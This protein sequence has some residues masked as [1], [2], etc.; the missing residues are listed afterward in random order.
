MRAKTQQT[1]LDAEKFK[2]T[3]EPVP[4]MFD[5]NGVLDEQLN[6]SKVN[7]MNNGR[8]PGNGLSDKDF[9]HLTCH[10]DVSLRSKIEKGEFVDLEKLLLK[11]KRRYSD[12]TR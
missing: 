6:F 12:D 5:E 4:G 1:I 7:L 11:D 10:I 9:F 2:A 3:I 8:N